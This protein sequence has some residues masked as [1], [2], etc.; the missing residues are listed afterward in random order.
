MFTLHGLQMVGGPVQFQEPGRD[1]VRLGTADVPAMLELAA[2]ARPGP[3]W[4]RTHELGSY[5][6]FREGGVLLAMAGERLHPPGW[7]EISAVCMASEARGRGLAALL[8]RHLAAGIVARGEQPF[9]HVSAASTSAIELYRRLG[10]TARR[11]FRGF[12][13]P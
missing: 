11:T 3:F 4:P 12:R 13:V 1:V 6:G 8:V 10:F 5:V 7:S 2:R 9:L